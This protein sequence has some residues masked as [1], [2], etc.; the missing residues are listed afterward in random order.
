MSKIGK[1]SIALPS[2]VEVTINGK[3]VS[4]KGGKGT[5]SYTLLDGV[6]AEITNGEV[7]V[8]IDS[9]DKKNLWGLSRTLIANM[10]EGVSKGYEK[11]LQVLGVGYTAKLQGTNLQLALGFSHPVVFPMPKAVTAAVV[12]DPKGNDIIT[13]TSIDKELIGETAAK[14]RALKAPEP[15]KGKGIRYFDEVVKLKAGKAAKK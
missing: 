13:L 6:N 7:V 15:Y 12:K 9:D 1:K 5:L 11:K 14:I 10:V 3:E 8:T 2:G 4:V